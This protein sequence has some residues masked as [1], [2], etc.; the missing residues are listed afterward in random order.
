[1]TIIKTMLMVGLLGL[2]LHFEHY[3][4]AAGLVVFFLLIVWFTSH[5]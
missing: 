2:A 1:M 3:W 5:G 4:V